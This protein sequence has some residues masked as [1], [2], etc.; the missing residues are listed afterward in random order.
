MKNF[1]VF[2]LPFLVSIGLF[3]QKVSGKWYG[4]LNV[5]NTSLRINFTIKKDSISYTSTMDSPDQGAFDIPTDKT[6]VTDGKIA[7]F[8]NAMMI[9][10][11]GKIKKDSII[12]VFTQNGQSFPL[13]LS[14]NKIETSEQ[15][16]R[17]QDPKEP[18]SLPC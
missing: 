16:R 9:N 15:K 1:S 4:K 17:P 6:N 13:N 8:I 12:G 18:F 7:V 2:V 14:K 5:Q 3:S 10:Y 11:K